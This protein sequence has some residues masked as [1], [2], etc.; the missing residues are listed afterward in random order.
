VRVDTS[1]VIVGAGCS[2][3]ALAIALRRAGVEDFMLLEKGAD[4]GGT[5]RDNDYPGCACDIP[6]YLYSYS[7]APSPGWTRMFPTQPEIWAYLRRCAGSYGVL[8]HLRLNTTVG[9]AEYDEAT[10]TWRVLVEGARPITC[11]A[12]VLAT[13]PLHV[14]SVPHLPGAGSFA[15]PSFHSARWDHAVDLTGKRVAV[16]GTGAS[17]VQFVPRIAPAVGHLDIYQRTPPWVLPK[18]DRRIPGWEKRLYRWLPP[19]QRLH[20][21]ALYWLLEWRVLGFV[22]DPRILRVAQRVPLRHLAGQVRDPDLRRR[23]TPSYAMGCKR[24]LLSNDYYPSLL[25]DNVDLVTDG[26]AA[27]G[28]DG[29][30]TADGTHRPADVIIYGT[31]FRVTDAFD[32]LH[33]RGRGG[34]TLR[35][36]WRGGMEAYLGMAVAGFPNLF[37]L[38]GP[39]SGLGHNSMIFMIE[40]QARYVTQALRA[41]LRGQAGAVEVRP[42]VQRAYNRQLQDRLAGTVW[43][44]GC[45]SWYLDANGVNRT[46]W[47]GFTWRY[48]LRTRR[49]DPADYR[50]EPAGSGTLSSG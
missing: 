28:P 41:L 4:L 47:P 7:F 34:V 29:V 2:G 15:G 20:R 31:G 38:L 36:A 21:S 43:S 30:L 49:L 50:T 16:I 5:W 14:P 39:N 18:P 45:R 10:G 25:R 26:I 23:L 27:I 42:S 32:G 48:W 44:T 24:V 13:G 33:L 40:A 35:E 6:S 17:A 1:V 12:V 19:L 8:P 46:L 9:G 3:I 37:L 11:R 22:V